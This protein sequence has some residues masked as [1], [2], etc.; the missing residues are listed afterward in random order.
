[1]VTR[2]AGTSKLPNGNLNALTQ[3][4]NDINAINSSTTAAQANSIFEAVQ[5]NNPD[6]SR[7][8][9]LPDLLDIG[10]LI[11][12]QMLIYYTGNLDAPNSNFLGNENPNN[13]YAIR[14]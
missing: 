4:Y 9:A 5:G 8:D 13:F 10:N 14:Q 11:Q 3:L 6:G 2:T 7:N 1:M 12:Y